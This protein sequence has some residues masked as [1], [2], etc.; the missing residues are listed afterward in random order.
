MDLALCP[1]EL[2]WL[3]AQ[4]ELYWSLL[5]QQISWHLEFNICWTEESLLEDNE[6][7]KIDSMVST[8]VL[9]A[10][11]M[12]EFNSSH[13]LR[14]CS[15]RMWGKPLFLWHLVIRWTVVSYKA[16]SAFQLSVLCAV[17]LNVKGGH[18]SISPGCHFHVDMGV[19]WAVSD[20]IRSRAEKSPVMRLWATGENGRQPGVSGPPAGLFELSA[21]YCTL[22]LPKWL[23]QSYL[24]AL[25]GEV[26]APEDDRQ[27]FLKSQLPL[28]PLPSLSGITDILRADF[29]LDLSFSNI[30][31]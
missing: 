5:I 3:R 21:L 14:V 9:L 24:V 20:Q 17:S 30:S 23:C 7:R 6:K 11:K 28:F 8:T 18:C 22:V 25:R 15:W 1:Q 10:Y 2:K 19:E 26:K 4:E 29:G 31:M 13:W 27:T 12:E 16:F